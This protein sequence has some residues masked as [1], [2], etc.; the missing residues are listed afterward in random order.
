MSLAG[1]IL[2]LVLPCLLGLPA[3]GPAWPQSAQAGLSGS[4][5][6]QEDRRQIQ[7]RFAQAGL[8]GARVEV[9][10]DGRIELAGEYENRRE[11][12][13]AFSIAQSV[14]GVRRVAPTTP[15]NVRYPVDDVAA[16]I[17]DLLD[18][19]PL[20]SQTDSAPPEPAMQKRG[21]VVGIGEFRNP[22]I[23]RLKYG[24]KDAQDF[25]R[26]LVSPEGGGFPPQNL[27]LL[28]DGA[29]TRAA[30]ETAL[31]RLAAEARPGDLVIL[32]VSSHG[33][34]LNDRGNMNIVAYDTEP[35]PRHNIFLTSL[36]DDRLARFIEAARASTLLIILDACYS[37]GAYA[38]VPGFLA[39]GAKDLFVEEDR[40]TVQGMP[41]SNLRYLAAGGKDLVSEALPP[42]A[43]A[44]PGRI[45]ISASDG[46]ERSWESEQLQNSFFTH[47]MLDGMRR[48]K[49][50]RDAFRY[51]GPVVTSEVRRE[52]AAR[53][54]PQAVFVPEGANIV[55]R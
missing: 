10:A 38:K 4:A 52:K 6:D 45:L 35:T 19:I 25:Y 24:A 32:Y 23:R 28:T 30:I 29:A 27:T 13:I 46:S 40:D 8:A 31:D 48:K 41:A 37:G 44:I 20:H 1:R 15:E 36:T 22:R 50:V 2:L 11:V 14:V 54:T 34:P 9:G 39:S 5:P 55:L 33:A 49:N 17:K 12:Q 47:Y 42:G 21:L 7:A 18:R 53:Q 43:D 16:R 26:F 3:A 51:A